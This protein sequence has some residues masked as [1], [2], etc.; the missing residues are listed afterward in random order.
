M[1][2]QPPLDQNQLPMFMDNVARLRAS[3]YDALLANRRALRKWPLPLL[4]V[5]KGKFRDYEKAMISIFETLTF[6][7]WPWVEHFDLG[8][9]RLEEHSEF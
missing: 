7:M 9:Q 8:C 4:Y 1:D 2:P 5:R 3:R 6:T